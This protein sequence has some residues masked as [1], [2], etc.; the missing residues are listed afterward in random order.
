MHNLSLLQR[1]ATPYPH[2]V[3]RDISAG[4]TNKKIVGYVLVL[5][6]EFDSTLIPCLGDLNQ[7]INLAMDDYGI[8]VGKTRNC[9]IGGQVCIAKGY[10]GK[11]TTN[12]KYNIFQGMY[13]E[14]KQRLSQYG[15][16][17]IVTSIS[18]QI[19]R[20][21]RAHE[22]IGFQNIYTYTTTL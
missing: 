14:M 1:M 13:C 18:T 8:S 4:G 19:P 9:I 15:Y 3:A 22:K 20:S 21:Q 10:R 6:K 5:L 2:V 12:T 17:C 11:T 16:D 7:H